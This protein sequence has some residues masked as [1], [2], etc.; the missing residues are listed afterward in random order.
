M[1]S[2][3]CLLLALYVSR[4][5]SAGEADR[6][7]GDTELPEATIPLEFRHITPTSFLSRSGRSTDGATPQLRREFFARRVGSQS[8][9]AAAKLGVAD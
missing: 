3:S 6:N 5:R 8:V 9:T 2:G 1:F 7:V 4:R